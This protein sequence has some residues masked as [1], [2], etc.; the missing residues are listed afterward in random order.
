MEHFIIVT[1][2]NTLLD[3]RMVRLKER[4]EKKYRTTIV[5]SGERRFDFGENAVYVLPFSISERG[6]IS[7]LNSFPPG[8]IAFGGAPGD[9]AREICKAKNIRYIDILAD[10]E[11]CADNAL[12]CAEAA[13]SLLISSTETALNGSRIAIFGYGRI[14]SRLCRMLLGHGVSVVVYTSDKK[15][16]NALSTRGIPSSHLW[17]RQ[18][19]DSFSSIVNTIPLHHVIPRETL[20]CLDS[21]TYILD[22]ASG[23]NNVD[24]AGVKLLGLHGEHATA[25]PG[26][27]SPSSAAAVLEKAIFK[28]LK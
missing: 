27:V 28:Y 1:P 22:L 5:P 15:E 3:K 7:L 13:L 23:N 8:C 16:L 20:S 25:L 11:F 14:G 24:W 2:E 12:I 9:E 19:I 6:T 26:K 18:D 10:E 4:L 17:Q 21:R